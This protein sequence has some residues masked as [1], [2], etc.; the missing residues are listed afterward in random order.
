MPFLLSRV[1]KEAPNSSLNTEFCASILLF[2]S[3]FFRCFQILRE[4]HAKGSAWELLRYLENN[5]CFKIQMIPG[6][7]NSLH[8]CT[9][10]SNI[11]PIV[12]IRENMITIIFICHAKKTSRWKKYSF[13]YGRIR[14]GMHRL[15]I[16]QKPLFLKWDMW[17]NSWRRKR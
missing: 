15:L 12:A 3:L 1:E 4:I 10:A 6:N 16:R 13:L 5:I 2:Q 17:I 14:V 7:R 8:K 9:H 11:S